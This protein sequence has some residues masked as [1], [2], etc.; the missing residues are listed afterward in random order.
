MTE[1][2]TPPDPDPRSI[3]FS[4]KG[5]EPKPTPKLESR[6]VAPDDDIVKA[7]AAAANMLGVDRVEFANHV[8]NDSQLSV[9]DDQRRRILRP[10]KPQ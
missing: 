3:H 10:D 6:T 1:I 8:W 5:F 7:V 4:R 2:Y 9:T